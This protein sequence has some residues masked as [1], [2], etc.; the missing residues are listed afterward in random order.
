MAAI[1]NAARRS[2]N[3]KRAMAI[4]AMPEHGRDARGTS[5][6]ATSRG[7]RQLSSRKRELT[8]L[9]GRVG[10]SMEKAHGGLTSTVGFG[11]LLG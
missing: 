11:V 6:C 5:A 4:L 9:Q 8:P 10:D 2:R 1:W 7:G 3:Q